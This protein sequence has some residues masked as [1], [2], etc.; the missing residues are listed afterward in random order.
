MTRSFINPVP[1]FA[2]FGFSQGLLIQNPA[3]ILE[4]S[5]QTSV[6]ATGAPANEGDMPAQ[7]KCVLDNLEATLTEAGFTLANLTRVMIF[8][9]DVDLLLEH[10]GIIEDRLGPAGVK[11]ASTLLG[12]TRLADPNL[13]VEIQATAI[14]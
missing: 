6:D 1:W 2:E 10:H 9:T 14:R 12:V 3:A 11:P 5:G 8:T 4:I 13:M 7:I